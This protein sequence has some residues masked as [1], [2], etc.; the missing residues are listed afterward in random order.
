[1]KY[2]FSGIGGI[3][4]SS[5]ALYTAYKYGIKN[6]LGS[7]NEMNERVEYL[8][9]KGIKVKLK[10]DSD[11]PDIDFLI[12]TTAIKDTNPELIE[13]KKRK[14]TVLNRMQLLNSILQEHTSIGITGTDGKT[15]TT[16]MVSQIFK[17][18]G[19]DPTV[20]LG[21]IHNSLE[22]GN[23]RYGNG[24]IIAE[25]D[26]SDGFI[27]ETKTNFS[28]V[29]NLRPDHLEHYDNKFEKLENSLYKFARNTKDLVILNGDDVHLSKWHLNENKVLY[30]GQ[31][32]KA[33]Y[34][35]KN[36]RQ[37]NG[38][39]VFELHHKNTHIGDIILN[40]PGLHYAYD[41]LASAVLSLEFGIDFKTIKETF[42]SYNSV[43][44][45]FNV[46]YDKDNLSI[47]DDYAHTPDEILATIKATKEN[48]PK[49][50][51]ITI[52]QPHRYT[53]LYF[54]INDFIDVL[55]YSDEVLVYRIY[56]AF[57]EPING[58]DERKVV[59]AL[60]SQSTFS[61]FYNS[62]EE[63]ISDLLLERNAVL[64]FVGAG[65]ITDIAKKLS[66]YKKNLD[67]S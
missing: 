38:Y 62:E 27:E 16:A 48:F 9:K 5:L 17:N 41:A 11:L 56:S 53:R 15:T 66:K 37:Y 19:K 33:D 64:L 49:R 60:N 18:V 12:K 39:Q 57:E 51:L 44:R 30:F 24:I 32:E 43:G 2:Y 7:N 3:G 55:K 26:E 59:E 13:A 58:V 21:G 45:R 1:M 25:V 4:M 22:D 65:D 36:R 28:I 47:I 52:F 67:I 50:K 8:I 40:L 14:I 34:T 54:H 29:N 31:G 6:V 42:Q 23:F 35:I 20:F 61:K 10:Q 63:I 46:L